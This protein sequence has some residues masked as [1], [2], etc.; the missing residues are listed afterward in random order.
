MPAKVTARGSRWL[1]VSGS[2]S[3]YKF[4]QPI[5]ETEHNLT[6]LI[7]LV[8]DKEEKILMAYKFHSLLL[9][10]GLPT[11]PALPAFAKSGDSRNEAVQKITS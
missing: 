5:G 2:S 1:V 11:S 4:Y 9:T 7:W 3:R 10:T 8:L 6:C